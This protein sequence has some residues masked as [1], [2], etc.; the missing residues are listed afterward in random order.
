MVSSLMGAWL[1]IG[2]R[3]ERGERGGRGVPTAERP[4]ARVLHPPVGAVPDHTKGNLKGNNRGKL[5]PPQLP[6]PNPPTPQSSPPTPTHQ[7]K[8]KKWLRR[9]TGLEA[10]ERRSQR[11]ADHSHSPPGLRAAAPAA[12]LFC[13]HCLV[14]PG[15]GRGLPGPGD[16]SAGLGWC[17]YWEPVGWLRL[18][19]AA[20]PAAAE[21]AAGWLGVP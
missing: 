20:G 18:V 2:S 17:R 9:D 13:Q 7:P 14:R 8:D 11:K 10:E 4:R 12:L 6:T 5:L 19:A 3:V 21:L 16:R 15:R 1:D